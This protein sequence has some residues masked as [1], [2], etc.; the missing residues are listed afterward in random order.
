M[1]LLREKCLRFDHTGSPL[2]VTQLVLILGICRVCLCVPGPPGQESQPGSVT[3]LPTLQLRTLPPAPPGWVLPSFL[4]K[5]WVI[6][7]LMCLPHFAYPFI[8]RLHL[9]CLHL[10]ALVDTDRGVHRSSRSAFSYVY[11]PRSRGA[12]SCNN[13]IL[14]FLRNL[15]TL[16]HIHCTILPAHRQHPRI[17][18]ISPSHQHLLSL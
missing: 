2:P 16:F 3:W 13:S 4:F 8:S 7:C 18:I 10:L 5:D 12:E 17:P 11:I 6:F 15:H 9:S 14:S 1:D